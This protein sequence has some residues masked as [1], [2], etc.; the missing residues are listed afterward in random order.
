MTFEI[1]N[2]IFATTGLGTRLLQPL[3]GHKAFFGGPRADLCSRPCFLL[4]Y[5]T[6]SI[7]GLPDNGC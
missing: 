1:A 7:G 5:C 3:W 6:F 4:F 2:H